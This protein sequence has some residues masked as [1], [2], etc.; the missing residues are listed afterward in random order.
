V[1]RTPVYGAPAR[2]LPEGG[3]LP[4]YRVAQQPVAGVLDVVTAVS[5]PI[6]FRSRYDLYRAFAHQMECAGVRL[7]TV[8]LAFGD[9][10]WEVTEPDNPRHVRLRTNYEVWHKENLLNLGIQR[11]PVDWRYVAW[12]DADI[13]FMNPDWVQD[14]L[15]SLQHYAIVQPWSV[16]FDLD[17]NHEP[18]QKQLGF[19]ACYLKEFAAGGHI[20]IDPVFD[21]YG[22]DQKPSKYPYHWHSGFAWAARREALDAV[23]GLID[24]AVLGSADR[25]MANC[26][27]GRGR[28][29]LP[30]GLHPHY[31]ELLDLWQ[32]NAERAIR[33]DIGCVP[34]TIAHA[35]HG[36]KAGRQYYDRA[37]IL[38]RFRFDPIADLVHDTQGLIQLV[39]DGSARMVGLRDA[40]RTY[41]RS[42]NED[43][44][45]S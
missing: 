44:I 40:I 17:S 24:W 13:T 9:R 14:T 3:G 37:K 39:D 5:N 26:L 6:R 35:W 10:D 32:Q 25:H 2:G 15:Q 34:G 23:G 43:S 33:R 11:L 27:I 1:L 8:E 28:E 18:L 16:A 12:I 7:T 29:A 30:A 20:T 4:S 19:V 45:I 21:A 36:P 42:R 31:L 38:T 41:F 22:P